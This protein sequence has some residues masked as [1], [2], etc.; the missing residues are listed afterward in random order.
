M[1]KMLSVLLAL[2]LMLPCLA[3]ADGAADGVYTAVCKGFYGDFGVNVT[4][5]TGSSRT[6]RGRARRRR[7][8]SAAR[9]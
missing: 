2:C 3:M 8:S 7:P 1:K 6:S 5:R 9:R 4:S